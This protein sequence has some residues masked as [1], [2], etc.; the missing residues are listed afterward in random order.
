MCWCIWQ[1]C[2]SSTL[3][4]VCCCRRV[5]GLLGP[6]TLR[7]LK[8]Q[9]RNGQ[10]IVKLP[11][12][13]VF[14]EH[15]HLSDEERS[16]YDAM[17]T[18]GKL[19]VSKWVTLVLSP[20]ATCLLFISLYDY[21]CYNRFTAL[22]P[23]LPGWAG[24]RRNIHPLT[25]PDHHPT[26]ISFFHLLRSVASSLFSLHTWQS[27]CTTS[28]QVLFGLPLGLDPSTSHS[29]HFFTSQCLLFAAHAHTITTCFVVVPIL[30]PLFL[31]SFS[32]FY[33]ELHLLP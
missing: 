6:L 23:G 4:D 25:Y 30:Y 7:R 20:V 9:I 2:P 29:I 1:Q 14:V 10:P 22:C 5:K 31:V 18:Q 28:L 3:T 13:D 26:F 33:L 15:L 21:Y 27:F 17:Q 24:T 11:K 19:I 12:R 8:T 16:L 32:T